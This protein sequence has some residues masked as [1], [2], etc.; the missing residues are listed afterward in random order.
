VAWLHSTL[1]ISQ[2]PTGQ[3]HTS[4][5]DD[6]LADAIDNRLMHNTQRLLLKGESM[7]KIR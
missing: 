7:R 2:L 5:G 4:V 3:W 6:T 1:T